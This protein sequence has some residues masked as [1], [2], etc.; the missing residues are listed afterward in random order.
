MDWNTWDG[1]RFRHNAVHLPD[2]P[3]FA[4]YVAEARALRALA[5]EGARLSFDVPC[6]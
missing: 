6:P 3:L 4:D 2:N 5:A 1:P